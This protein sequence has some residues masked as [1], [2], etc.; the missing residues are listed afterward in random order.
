MA[1]RF[2]IALGTT[3]EYWMN[4]QTAWELHETKTRFKDEYNKIRPIV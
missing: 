1:I 3:P 4:L 2:S